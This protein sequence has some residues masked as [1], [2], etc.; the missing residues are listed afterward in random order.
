MHSSLINQN[1]QPK[2]PGEQATIAS[3]DCKLLFEFGSFLSRKIEESRQV[4]KILSKE[5][6]KKK[7]HLD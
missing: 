5:E 4:I 7:E 1:S 2:T 6:L 3:R